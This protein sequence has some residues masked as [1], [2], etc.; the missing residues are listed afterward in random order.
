M[1]RLPAHLSRLVAAAF[2]AT[3]LLAP[4]QAADSLAWFYVYLQPAWYT[5][6]NPGYDQLTPR[7]FFPPQ[8]RA[9][10]TP[11]TGGTAPG[12][13]ATDIRSLM[14]V[15]YEGSKPRQIGIRDYWASDRR[16]PCRAAGTALRIP[17]VPAVGDSALD[18]ATWYF[19]GAAACSEDADATAVP[20][21]TLAARDEI[22][23]GAVVRRTA[24]DGGQYDASPMTIRRNG[25]SWMTY[26]WGYRL[27]LVASTTDWIPGNAALAPELA[28][29]PALP[30]REDELELM[31]L[32]PPWIEDDVVEYVNRADFPWQPDGQYFYAAR[33]EDK[34]ALDAALVWQRSGRTFKSGGYVSVCRFYA[35]NNG[36]PNTHFYSA[37]AS[38]CKAL[39]Q[40]A[41]LTYEGQ[42]FAVNL[43]LPART[44][45]QGLPG[46]Q[47]DCPA[48]SRPLFRLY[49][50]PAPGSRAVANHRYTTD[51]ADVAAFT[52]RGWTDE[53]H[54]MCVPE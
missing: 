8:V 30:R 34:A 3:G 11:A 36:G 40:I 27:G 49:N 33:L 53:G 26:H 4:V 22:T 31:T 6:L 5:P 39:R 15:Q 38:E 17:P 29:W 14:R 23:F 35:G 32:P 41:A 16:M 21:V 25:V 37:D 7:T 44:E 12:Y 2:V 18:T 48:G 13:I 45:Q 28:A 1:T 52:A 24:V 42:T 9:L 19:P 20:N 46:A 47:R 50:N 10:V 54:V 51:R 43:P